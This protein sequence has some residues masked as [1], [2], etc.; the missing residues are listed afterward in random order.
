MPPAQVFLFTV[1]LQPEDEDGEAE[2]IVP[3][4]TTLAATLQEAE[5]M[6]ARSVPTELAELNERLSIIVKPF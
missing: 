4:R 5:D 6:A 1:I 2:L 3:L